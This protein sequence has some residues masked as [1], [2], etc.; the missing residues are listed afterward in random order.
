VQLPV[1][2]RLQIS[3]GRAI[4]TY[5]NDSGNWQTIGSAPVSPDA[6]FRTGL[7]V[8]S[9]IDAVLTTVKAR[10]GPK[11]DNDLP[12]PGD[13]GSNVPSGPSLLVNGSFE[14]QG[15]Q[16]D[17][18]AHWNRWGP[19]MN[20]ETAWTPTHSGSS[21]IGY[22]HWQV[23]SDASS[24]L[25]QDVEVR[26]GQRYVFSFYAQHDQ[27]EAAVHDAKT[28]ELRTESVTPNGQV[29]LNS[30]NFDIA[31]LPTG[32][33][34]ARLSIPSTAAG[35]RMRVLAI[36]SPAETGPRGGAVKLDDASLVLASGQAVGP[37]DDSAAR[38]AAADYDPIDETAVPPEARPYR[39]LVYTSRGTVNLALDLFLPPG[40]GPFPLVIWIHGGA[41][42][43]GD[44]AGYPHM[45]FL[46][47]RRFAVAN[48]EYRFS[49]VAPFPAQLDDCESA[50]DFLAAKAATY[51]LDPNRIAVSGESAGGHLASLLGMSRSARRT[52]SQS[53]P[54]AGRIG[55]VVDLAGP[56]DLADLYRDS[57]DAD[58]RRALERLVGGPPD[59][60]VE[61]VR[62][63]NPVAQVAKDDPPFLIL[64]G[65]ADPLVPFSQSQRL[66]DALKQAGADVQL[67]PIPNAGHVGP[68]FW[69]PARREMIVAFLQRSMNLP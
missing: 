32:R 67:V 54:A 8:C 40:E 53:D 45:M 66:A 2:L 30:A 23:T 43:M 11:A 24:G 60:Q 36:I 48:I 13:E 41:W 22:H 27:V 7:A 20:R 34:W 29:T 64:H 58:L 35:D 50:L 4:G 9:H 44:K 1:E 49:Q 38:H 28:L 12:A 15:D 6:G 62:Q 26:P 59:R 55:A 19:W 57:Q 68:A 69:I 63:A 33:S 14:Q 18:A 47:R 52:T 37:R 16:S 39:D 5:R 31:T 3:A 17:L 25:W 10:L 56:S 65:T 21:E 61:L 46:L 51:H 42:E